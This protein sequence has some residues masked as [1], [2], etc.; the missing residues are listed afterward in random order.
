[1]YGETIYALATAAGRAGVAVVRISGEAAGPALMRL[2][3]RPLPPPRRAVLRRFLDTDGERDR[4]RDGVGDGDG[5]EALD[6]GLVLWFPG[7]GSFTGED[8]V[9]LHLH[10][11]R[12]V[13]GG[14]LRALGRLPGL[15]PA[16]PGEFSRRAFA[17]GR[18]DLT[19][20][21]GLAD[22]VAAETAAQRRQALAQMGGALGRLYD[23]WRQRL[24]RALAHLEAAIDFA[25]EELPPELVA[26]VGS[27]VTRLL[28]EMRRHL[29]DAGRGERIRGGIEI[30]VI[31]PP[32]AGKSTL[33]N[34]LARREVAIVSPHPGTTRDVIEVPL[35]M[36]GYAV[37]LSDTAGL[38]ETAGEAEVQASARAIEGEG[39][40]RARARASAADVVIAVFDGA[41]WPAIDGETAAIAVATSAMV[42]INKGDLGRVDGAA[43]I[44]GN[45]AIVV[46]AMTGEGME[47]LQAMLVATIE[48]RF[49]AG[50]G[51]VLSRLRHRQALAAAV[52][53]LEAFSP[54][55]PIE[56]AAEELRS[57][58]DALGRITG[59]VDVEEMLDVIFRDFCI[60]K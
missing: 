55:K 32:N 12:A 45:P 18:F 44:G 20:A 9:E 53:A 22:L 7:P 39:I 21:E 30:A 58:I 54:A 13:V 38:R 56:E 16:E 24:L 17:N 27:Q 36:A 29:D 42:L 49:A 4:Q 57:A 23:G 35:D 25:D 28:A 41:A 60:G 26:D 46:S 6:R 50:E 31:G 48:S 40:R 11:G 3:G 37:V 1:M 10:G 51:P 19:A 34:A 2:T 52:A 47:S 59:R 14:V 15:R 43:M 33:V 5:A 8:V